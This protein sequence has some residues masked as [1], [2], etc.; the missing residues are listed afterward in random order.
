MSG[1]RSFVVVTGSMEP[2]LKVGT[3]VF[4]KPQLAY[5]KNDIVA[6]E[7]DGRTI[8][9]R[10]VNVERQ[11]SQVFYGTK[12]DANNTSDIKKVPTSAIL[13]KTVL[14]IPYIGSIVTTFKTIPGFIVFIVIPALIFIGFELKNIKEEIVKETEKRLMS[15]SSYQDPSLRSG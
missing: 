10:I 3:L 6:F 5:V 8:T 2:N 11:K 4:T 7:Q 15:K 1:M 14:A 12:G 13:G 9:H